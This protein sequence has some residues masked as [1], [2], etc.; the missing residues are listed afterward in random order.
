M[1]INTNFLNKLRYTLYAPVYDWPARI[2]ETSRQKAILHLAPKAGESILIIGAGTGMDLNYLPLGCEITATDLTP[3]MIQQ[4]DKR[5]RKLKHKLDTKVMDGQNLAFKNE[6]FDK[7]IL[8]LIV[9]VIPDPIRT[10]RE[11]ERVL[12]YGGTISVFDK[13]VPKNQQPSLL[14]KTANV[15]TNLFFSDITRSFEEIIS[16]TQLQVIS[17]VPADFGGNF[18][19]ILLKK[20]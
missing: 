2:L 20:K 1:R 5:N 14:R 7:V 18:R 12:K 13:F 3:A 10:I 4:I 19:I 9:S 8:H 17:D 11:A 15:L 16:H 6:L